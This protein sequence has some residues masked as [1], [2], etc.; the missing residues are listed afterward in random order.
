MNKFILITSFV[1]VSMLPFYGAQA[2][3][4]Y[5][6]P[7]GNDTNNGL[8]STTPFQTIQVAVNSA[9][10]GDTIVLG[11]GVYLQD[12]KTIGHGSSSGP[13]TITGS[14]AAIVQGSGATTRLIEINHDYITLNGFTVDGLVG[15]GSQL[16][17]YRGKLIYAIGTAPLDGV[18][19]VKITNMTLK[20]AGDECVRFRYFAQNNEIANNTITNCGVHDFRFNAG[21]KNGEG[22]YI[23]TAPEQWGLNGAPTADP[24]QSNNNWVHHNIINTQ[25]A[26]CVDVKEAATGNIV[27][28]NDCTGVAD[29]DTGALDSRGNGNIFRYNNVHH[30]TSA[31]IR[32]GGDT[33]AWGINNDIYENT[34]NDN[35]AGGIKFM[36]T[37]QG[38]VC[39]NTMFNNTGGDSVGTY[40]DSFNPTRLCSAVTDTIAPTVEITN[41]LNGAVVK[42]SSTITISVNATDNIGVTK[43]E[44]FVDGGLKCSDTT[45][46]FS[47]T[48]KVPGKANTTY[49][50]KAVAWDEALNSSS[51]TIQVT[52]R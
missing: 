43:V 1:F 22:I 16:A 11:D 52:A 15:N 46:P 48:W 19:G 12:I 5:V 10:A 4:Y 23:G 17:D 9:V 32:L 34:I 33:S 31:G 37:P 39:G 24:D 2:T 18:V 44:F 45:I 36:N 50:L 40:K 8:A 7:V 14:A 28:N 51:H 47:C 27:E 3:E 26:E 13:I 20:N 30:N 35:A 25:G 29:K 21:G 49:V 41:P 38:K 6:S 42:R